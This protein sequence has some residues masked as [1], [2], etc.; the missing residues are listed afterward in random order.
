MTSG[1]LKGLRRCT[2][3]YPL[4][5][6]PQEMS[7]LAGPINTLLKSSYLIGGSTDVESTFQSLFDIAEEVAQVDCCAYLSSEPG[8][9]G[10]Q[11]VVL[12]GPTPPVCDEAARRLPA[13]LARLHGKAVLLEADAAPQFQSACRAWGADSL[14]AF[15]L[16]RDREFVGALIFGTRKPAGLPPPAVKLLFAL[17]MQAETQLLRAE[18]VKALS[19]YSFLDP[20]THLSNRRYFDEQIE[21]EILR[22]RRNGKPF[23][24]LMLDLDGFKAYNDRFMHTAGDIALQELGGLLRDTLREVDTAARLGGDEF[25][26]ILVETGPE[27]ARELA[28]RIL[29][30]FSRHLLPGIDGARTERITAS[31]GIASFPADSFDKEDL[32]RKADRAL[33]LAKSQGGGRICLHHEIGELLALKVSPRDV[34]VHK[35]YDAARSIVDMDKFLEILLFTAMQALSAG[36]GSIVAANDDGTFDL[37]AAIGFGNGE[38]QRYGPGA[39]V[40]AGPVTAWVVENRRPLLAH[41]SRDW[42]VTGAPR[43]NGYRSD[44][45]LSIPLVHEGRLVG[46]INLTNRND[47]QPFTQS[48]IESFAPLASRIAAILA[49]GMR[50]RENA[51]LFCAEMLISLAGAL[52]LRFPF[53]SGHGERVRAIALRAGAQLGLAPQALGALDVAAAVHDVG[54][55]GIPGSI[56]AKKRRLSDRELEIARKHPLLG[57][58]MLEGVPGMDAARLAILQHH[59]RFDGSGYPYGLKGDD[60]GLPARI[61]S[62]AEFYDSITS[63]RPYRGGLLREEALQ[64]VRTGAGTLFDPEVARAFIENP[65]ITRP[66]TSSSPGSGPVSCS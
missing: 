22:S 39:A 12:R 26:I 58:K 8:R 7:A 56:M 48:D 20:L 57:A 31:I 41:G 51:R 64:M 54:I 10:F 40:A 32:L 53:L 29:E 17:A 27:G 6:S 46:T 4:D 24:L 44:S 55:V 35:I 37:R 3:D 34:P 49:E 47:K 5:I 61:L 19:F 66:G 60:I 18:A 36:R 43:K 59:E 11:V 15:P 45:F 42:P 13:A 33:Y 38:A 23:S 1:D 2:V 14:V 62:V 21:R 16:H 65:D 28:G 30:R 63:P 9:A 52:E 25:A 50:F